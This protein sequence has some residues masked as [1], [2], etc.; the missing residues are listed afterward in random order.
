[1]VDVT[2]Y[3]GDSDHYLLASRGGTFKTYYVNNLYYVEDNLNY[4][5]TILPWHSNDFLALSLDDL[6]GNGLLDDYEEYDSTVGNTVTIYNKRREKFKIDVPYGFTMER[7]TIDSLDSILYS[8]DQD[9]SDPDCLSEERQCCT[10]SDDDVVEN[11]SDSD[12]FSCSDS[13][14]IL[15]DS[16]E[17]DC[18][19]NWPRSMF[20]LRTVTDDDGYG[21]IK[22]TFDLKEVT[23]QNTFYA[24][25]SLIALHN[26]GAII[27]IDD[28]KFYKLTICGGIIKNTF[29][30]LGWP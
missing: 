3:L 5:I 18:F 13:F 6:D 29:A 26:A 25:N 19:A 22:N 27:T 1:M 24:M 20:K 23:I 28:S 21:L 12:T 11:V 14:T 7:I 30:D 4:N 9:E 16:M 17:T 10:I 8:H 2:I 15:M